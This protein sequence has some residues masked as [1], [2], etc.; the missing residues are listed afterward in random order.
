MISEVAFSVICLLL[1]IVTNEKISVVC[2]LA[3]ATKRETT[4]LPIA[5]PNVVD[6]Y[7]LPDINSLLKIPQSFRIF[8]NCSRTIG[9]EKK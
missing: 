9:L 1:L 2:M 7:T 6:G 5:M 4:E 8:A 3:H